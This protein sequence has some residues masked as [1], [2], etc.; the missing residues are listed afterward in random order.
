[1]GGEK[2]TVSEP[3]VNVEARLMREGDAVVIFIKDAPVEVRQ[4]RMPKTFDKLVAIIEKAQ[5]V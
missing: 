2:G 4:Q 3:A 1:M 5:P